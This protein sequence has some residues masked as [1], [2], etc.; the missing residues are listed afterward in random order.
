MKRTGFA[1]ISEASERRFQERARFGGLFVNKHIDE[2]AA[3][4]RKEFTGIPVR[5]DG[6]EAA[7][8]PLTITRLKKQ[9]ENPRHLSGADLQALEDAADAEATRSANA[10]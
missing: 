9:L 5:P 6:T 3:T 7:I 8:T 1:K 10:P 4:F 2:Y